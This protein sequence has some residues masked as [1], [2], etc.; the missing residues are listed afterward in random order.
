MENIKVVGLNFYFRLD[1][2]EFNWRI[3]Y[4]VITIILRWCV[5]LQQL[6]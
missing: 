4:K 6:H 3:G 2:D 5:M 1:K